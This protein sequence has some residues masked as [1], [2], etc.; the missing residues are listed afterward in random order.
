MTASVPARARATGM[1]C[2]LR[3]H[4]PGGL[5]Q[6]RSEQLEVPRPE[7]GEALV[8]VH[9]AA[10][11]RDEPGWPSDRLPAIPSY[12]LS[13]AVAAIGPGVSGLA[14]GDELFALTRFDPTAAP[15]STRSCPPICWHPSR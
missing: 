15:P 3:L 12:E 8:R 1:M 9:A 14:V 2:A 4:A 11:T 13:G 7:A 6:L 10:I 5:D